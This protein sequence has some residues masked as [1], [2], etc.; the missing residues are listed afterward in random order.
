MGNK[1]K[2]SIITRTKNRVL[3]LERAIQSVLSQTFQ[4]WQHI[5][6]D[7]SDDEFLNKEVI[8]KYS[9]KYNHRL[10]VLRNNISKGPDAIINLGVEN[11]DGD[12]IVILD[13]D[14]TWDDSFLDKTIRY[15]ECNKVQGVITY[16][17]YVIEKI[18]NNCVTTFNAYPFNNYISEITL[19]SAILSGICPPPVSFVFK[20]KCWEQIGGFDEEF[21]IAGDVEFILRFLSKYKIGIVEEV[22]ANYHV[23]PYNQG[24]QSNSSRKDNSFWIKKIFPSLLKKDLKAAFVYFF[25]NSIKPTRDYFLSKKK[26]KSIKGKEVAL[27]GAGIRAQELLPHLRNLNIV[28]VFDS[29]KE[30]QGQKL[31]KYLIFAPEQI[32]ELNPDVVLLTVAN[33]TMIKPFVEK[34]IK[35]NGLSTE[36]VTLD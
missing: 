2:V 35:E 36:I 21:L 20:R 25:L 31:G 16:S 22:L 34:L 27:Y 10:K 28:G 5:I 33:S 29:S 17:N 23:R 8:E 13:D 12:Y 7:D 1:Y 26:L 11:A 24:L 30:K 14:D 3:L 32:K 6:V 19:K 15:L 4:D 9:S 18:E